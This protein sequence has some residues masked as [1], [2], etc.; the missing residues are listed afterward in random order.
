MSRGLGRVE[1]EL[2]ELVGRDPSVGVVVVPEGAPRGVSESRRRAARSLQ[3]KG[4]ATIVPT[5]LN[6][7]RRSVL[8]GREEGLALLRREANSE[9]LDA[10]IARL[11]VR[12]EARSLGLDPD[13]EV[14]A[15]R[16]E[17]IDRTRRD[18]LDA[19]IA[20][21]RARGRMLDLGLDPDTGSPV[22]GLPPKM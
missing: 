16:G 9:M 5:R 3:D 8:L 11:E 14:G 12:R 13:A 7:R 17:E 6:G 1:R 22:E 20:S 4:L 2:L 21:R 19:E 18:L 15:S 10:E